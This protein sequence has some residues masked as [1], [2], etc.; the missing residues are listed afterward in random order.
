MH[1]SDGWTPDKLD[2]QLKGAFGPS[3]TPPDRTQDV[4][5]WDPV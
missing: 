2:T 3:L 5:S 1:R 4:F